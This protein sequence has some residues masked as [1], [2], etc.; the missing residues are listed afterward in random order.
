[1]LVVTSQENSLL[2]SCNDKLNTRFNAWRLCQA[3]ALHEH[4]SPNEGSRLQLTRDQNKTTGKA[5]VLKWFLLSLDRPNRNP[6]S[7][8]NPLRQRD[9]AQAAPA[10]GRRFTKKAK[11]THDPV[12]TVH[13]HDSWTV[14][15]MCIC[16]CIYVCIRA[17]THTHV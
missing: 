17:H 1:M 11:Q 12:V 14:A 10:P 7:E 2:R 4:D 16:I 5:W 8:R 9:C 3:P 6:T 13:L 15:V